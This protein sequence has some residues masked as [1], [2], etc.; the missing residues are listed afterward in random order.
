MTTDQFFF[1]LL[2]VGPVL[3]DAGLEPLDAVGDHAQVGEEHLLAEGGQLGGRVA[4]GE[5]VQDDQQGV[6]LAD[7]G[8]PLG[9]VAVGAGDQARAC[10]GT[11]PWPA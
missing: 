3:L 10:R 2:P 7:H 5:S 6:S 9:V 8:Q 11:R 4:A 1:L